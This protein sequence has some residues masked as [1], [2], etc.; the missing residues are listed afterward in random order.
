MFQTQYFLKCCT[1][2]SLSGSVLSFLI[3][4]CVGHTCVQLILY[5][6][7]AAPAKIRQTHAERPCFQWRLSLS[8]ITALVRS[9][10]SLRQKRVLHLCYRAAGGPGAGYILII[11]L[12][13]R[14]SSLNV[15]LS[16][17]WTLMSLEKPCWCSP[18]RHTSLS[19]AQHTLRHMSACCH[20]GGTA[21]QKY[22]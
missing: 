8:S 13:I 2:R 16:H 4:L 17:C 9:D 18:G 11:P 12:A 3:S 14:S 5:R 6:S 21:W 20:F 7:T 10:P 19:A 22:W 1:W 15:K